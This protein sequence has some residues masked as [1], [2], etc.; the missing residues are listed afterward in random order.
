MCYDDFMKRTRRSFLSVAAVGTVCSISGCAALNRD[1]QLLVVIYNSDEAQH[2]LRLRISQNGNQILQ[3]SLEIPAE[4]QSENGRQ[5][6]QLTLA[7]ASGS[8]VDAEFELEN[9]NKNNTTVSLDCGP[10]YAGS[11][12]I[13]RIQQ[14][15]LIE[16]SNDQ[17][18]NRCFKND[19]T[20]SNRG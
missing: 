2:T 5:E 17:T 13:A 4:V 14:S 11:S 1:T 10:E 18:A 19:E 15:G 8:R 9:G 7:G 20:R 3:Q 6:T 12:I 16:L